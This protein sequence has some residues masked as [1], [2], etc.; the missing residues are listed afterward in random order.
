MAFPHPRSQVNRRPTRGF[1][2]VEL[3]VVI[4]IIALLITI[5]L[6]A[7]N[8][9]R[10]AAQVVACSSN[11]R[12]IGTAWIAYS[13][14]NRGWWPA[15]NYSSATVVSGAEIGDSARVC[16]GYTLEIL[17]SPYTGARRE[18]S[19]V[20]AT[21]QVVGGIWICPA[22][23]AVTAKGK[24]AMGYIYPDGGDYDRN[25]YSGLYYQERESS[26]YIVGG[27]PQGTVN[28]W[29]SYFYRDVQ[30]EMPLQW[31]SMRR[32]GGSEYTNKIGMP[33]HHW[34][35]KVRPTLFVDGHVGV[36]TNPKYVSDINGTYQFMTKANG[37]DAPHRLK[38]STNGDKFAVG[39]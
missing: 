1:T 22:S 15:M 8:K 24:Y 37:A 25:T 2:L 26:H 21:K 28:R 32:G 4:G 14:D 13:T 33:S 6:P 16:E 31:C 29:K 38:G 19:K 9:A 36:L 18:W 7:L 3:L 30:T 17:L 35:A 27:V 34:P 20:N 23:G 10:T 11:L 12:Q 5:L 39:D